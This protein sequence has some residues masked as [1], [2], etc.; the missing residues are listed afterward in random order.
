[1]MPPQIFAA[2]NGNQYNWDTIE[3]DSHT[4]YVRQD[5]VEEALQEIIKA[6]NTISVSSP[7]RRYVLDML[8]KAVELLK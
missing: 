3:S 1:M 2:K 6:H 4:R 8:K 7:D 5:L